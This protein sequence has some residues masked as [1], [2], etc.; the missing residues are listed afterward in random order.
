M[1]FARLLKEL[2]ELLYEIM[3]WLVFYPI[4]LWKVI[5]RPAAMM[6]Y[7][8]IQLAQDKIDRYSDTLSPPIFLLVTMLLA[9]SLELAVVGENPLVATTGGLADLISDNTSLIMFRMVAFSVFPVI[10]ATLL[11]RR[12]RIG[13]NRKTLEA[14]FYAQCYSAVPFA[15][16]ISLSATVT[17]LDWNDAWAVAV[18]IQASALLWYLVV[19]TGWFARHLGVSRWRA[20]GDAIIGLVQCVVLLGALLVLLG[21]SGL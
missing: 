4:T 9:H 13:V 2:D 15:L 7:A 14:P 5:R 3:A 1:S 20:L 19:Q 21:G 18:P 17:R 12:Q 11:V 16:A 8:G 10:M 6:D